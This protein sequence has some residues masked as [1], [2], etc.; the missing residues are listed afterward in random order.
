MVRPV[1]AE[2]EARAILYVRMPLEVTPFL[3]TAYT[4]PPLEGQ[5]VHVTS[6]YVRVRA[7][8]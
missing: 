6:S 8:T 4:F 3:V 2:P 1:P 5:G 7:R